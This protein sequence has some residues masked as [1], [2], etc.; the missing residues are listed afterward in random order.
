MLRKIVPTRVDWKKIVD[1][2]MTVCTHARV[3]FL[4]NFFPSNK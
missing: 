1:I 3:D 4:D 2:V